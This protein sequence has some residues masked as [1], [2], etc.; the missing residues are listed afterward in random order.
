MIAADAPSR[1]S[2]LVRTMLPRLLEILGSDCGDIAAAEEQAQRAQRPGRE[3]HVAGAHHPIG[4]EEPGGRTAIDHFV[5]GAIGLIRRQRA[6]IA[7]F[8]FRPNLRA[9]FFGEI[10]IVFDERV[11]GAVT[12]AYHAA[13]AVG[14]PGPIGSFAAEV[15]IGHCLARLAKKRAD[16][17]W[18]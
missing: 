4:F 8:S 6:H 2:L 7:H 1:A 5:T 18:A 9:P 12:T 13:A 17:R 14:A 15:R 16:V 10:E 11:F 3:D